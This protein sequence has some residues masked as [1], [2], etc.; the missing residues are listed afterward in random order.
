LAAPL[1]GLEVDRPVEEQA[2]EQLVAD[3]EG[4]AEDQCL[5]GQPVAVG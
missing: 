3:V 2:A 4:L 5:G 1:S